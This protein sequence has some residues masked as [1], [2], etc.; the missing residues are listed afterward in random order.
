MLLSPEFGHTY[1]V[2]HTAFQLAFKTDLPAWSWLEKPGQEY[3]LRRFAVA[4]AG[5][6]NM[7]APGAILQ[8]FEWKTVPDGSTV[9]DVGG[10]VG[11]QSLAI[12]KAYPRLQFVVQDRQ[13][14]I[15]GAEKVRSSVQCLVHS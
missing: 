1:D 15:D 5:V 4:M 12:S 9:V 14:V 2:T 11:A 7:A 8:G 13:Q 6:Q 10:G 3:A